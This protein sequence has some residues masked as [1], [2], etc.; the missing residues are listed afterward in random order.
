MTAF[1]DRTV[2]TIAVSPSVGSLVD[3]QNEAT[4]QEIYLSQTID[5][6]QLAEGFGLFWADRCRYVALLWASCASIIF[7]L[8]VLYASFS[9][10]FPSTLTVFLYC[11]FSLWYCLVLC[12]LFLPPLDH[13]YLSRP[14]SLFFHLIFHLL[15]LSISSLIS[16]FPFLSF[17]FIHLS[18]PSSLPLS[19]S[20]PL[21]PWCF[22]SRH[23]HRVSSI[24]DAEQV[25]VFS[26]G[27]LVESDSGPNLLA[28]E[29][30]LFS[31][32][33]RTHK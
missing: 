25:L 16:P 1:A 31:V 4:N 18:L 3:F 26:S 20:R 30:S 32:L 14:P 10:P 23:Q 29:E 12:F 9:A 28:Q 6:L 15:I 5:T 22:L 13:F 17:L 33:V 27:I 24:L 7:S 8:K 11:T 19:L 2:V 21:S